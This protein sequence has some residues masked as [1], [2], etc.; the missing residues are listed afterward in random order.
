[1]VEEVIEGNVLQIHQV[2]AGVPQGSPVS[3]ILF[4]LHTATAMVWVEE[5]VQGLEGLSCGDDHCWVA[6]LNDM[7]QMVWKLG[8][9]GVQS[10]KWASRRDVQYHTAKIEAAPCTLRRCH[11]KN[12]RPK[13]TAKIIV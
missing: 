4:T 10:I 3:Q 6:T 8:A 13:L 7:N 9:C 12:L 2:E 11:Q 1:M 5:S